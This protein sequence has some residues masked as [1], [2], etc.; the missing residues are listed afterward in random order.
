MITF[1][2]I[3]IMGFFAQYVDGALGMGY[4]ASSSSFLITTGLA[5]AIVSA[6]VHTSEIFA[7]FASGLSHLRL[8]NVKRKIALPLTCTGIV[9]GVIGAYFLA[10]LP[11]KLMS[12]FVG[13]ILLFLGVRIFLRFLWKKHIV[14]GKGEFSDKF[15]L[16]LG[17]VGATVDA[18]GGGGWGP[19]CTSTLVSAN[20][21][22]LRYVIGSV[23]MAE[24]FATVAIVFTFGSTL[25][26]ENFLWYVTIPLII[27]G[28]LAAPMAAHTSKKM[29]PNILGTLVG[30]I[31]IVLN[32]R[33]VAEY[34]PNIIG[35][36]MTVKPELIIVSIV[37]I[38][39][40]LIV[41][42]YI[43]YKKG[44]PKEVRP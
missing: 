10:K 44:A 15:L 28:I 22:E 2:L 41:L 42:R 3:L 29:P 43:H 33:T 37:I 7:S 31:L 11:G 39:V 32:T 14:L 40:F 24:F 27:G 9:G 6:S 21:T 25:G 8:G 12:P 23:N 35:M 4:G 36:E 16:F 17:F 1:L 18:I 34:L 20:K 26:F 19:I 13:I 5:P 30:A 38:L